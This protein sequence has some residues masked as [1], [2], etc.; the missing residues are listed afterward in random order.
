VGRVQQYDPNDAAGGDR[1]TGYTGALQYL[2]VGDDLKFQ[3]EYTAFA[4]QG[5]AIASNRVIVQMQAR[6]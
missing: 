6:F 2:C 1:V 5:A 3:V 4:E